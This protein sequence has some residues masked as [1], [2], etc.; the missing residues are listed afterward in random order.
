MIA[1]MMIVVSVIDQ[2]NWKNSKHYNR[3]DKMNK[4]QIGNLA[5]F[6]VC[7]VAMVLFIYLWKLPWWF[8]VLFIIPGP[9]SISIDY[10]Y[11]KLKKNN[12]KG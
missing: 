10:L 6:F 11:K 4:Y 9:L 1:E 7:V 3:R 2:W 12:I 8:F 5:L